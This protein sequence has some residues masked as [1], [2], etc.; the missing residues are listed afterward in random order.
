MPNRTGM[1]QDGDEAGWESRTG[2][3]AANDEE[4]LWRGSME[5]GE[6]EEK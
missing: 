4:L 6:Q 3:D 1:K 5:K 2:R